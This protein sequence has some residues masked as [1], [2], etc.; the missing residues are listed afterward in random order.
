MLNRFLWRIFM[1]PIL[2][3][4]YGMLTNCYWKYLT[5]IFI[6]LLE[7]RKKVIGGISTTQFLTHHSMTNE[8]QKKQKKQQQHQNVGQNECGA[9]AIIVLWAM[10]ST[11]GRIKPNFTAIFIW[12]SC[13]QR[14][15]VLRILMCQ[16][17][18]Y[19]THMIYLKCARDF[20]TDTN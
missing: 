17:T 11:V 12:V 1:I 20:L 19:H 16:L 15:V 2:T 3:N 13:Y 6:I 8:K 9:N 5:Q 4:C 7:F 14:T 10:D 18:K